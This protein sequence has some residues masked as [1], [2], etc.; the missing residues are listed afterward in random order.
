MSVLRPIRRGADEL[1]GSASTNGGA[2]VRVTDVVKTYGTINALR[3][4]SLEV[5]PGEFVTI[6]DPSGSGKSTLL[7]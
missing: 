2:G 5:D 7:T 1:Q 4:V 3:G 6:T